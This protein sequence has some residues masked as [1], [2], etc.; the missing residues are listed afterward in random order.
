MEDNQR[1]NRKFA[2][3]A[4]LFVLRLARNWLKVVLTVLTIYVSLPFIAPTLM[5]LGLEAP[6]RLIYT[7]YTPFCHQ[8]PFRTIFLYG[9]QP[10][11]PRF[12]VPDTGLTPF[13]TYAGDLSHFSGI[14][15]YGFDIDV[16]NSG[17]SFYGNEQ[18]GYKMTLCARDIAI[19]IS[20]LAVGFA[21]SIPYVR[22][23]LRPVPIWLYVFLGLGPIG[24]D[25]VS[26]LLS[27]PPFELWPLRETTPF[28]RILTGAVFGLMT[29]WLAFPYLQ[30]SFDDTRRVIE[31]K[32]F[33]AGI[34]A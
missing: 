21:Y 11:Y 4:N 1:K 28:Y 33:R 22:R 13:E 19:Y 9:E 14:D 12:N 23:R 7:V 26:Q 32:L 2:L 3:K 24:L 16:L 27:Y 6:A 34:D 30:E 20:M 25:G 18:M 5:Y 15:V 17:R 10:M 31:Q 29:G 8:L